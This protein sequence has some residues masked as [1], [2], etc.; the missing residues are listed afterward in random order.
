MRERNTWNGI[1][2]IAI[3]SIFVVACSRGGEP[4]ASGSASSAPAAGPSETTS[5]AAAHREALA[6]K[7]FEPVAMRPTAR[8]RAALDALVQP[9]F[10]LPEDQIRTVRLIATRGLRADDRIQIIRRGMFADTSKATQIVTKMCGEAPAAL[11]DQVSNAKPEVQSALLSQKCKLES[12]VPP[13]VLRTVDPSLLLAG[14]VIAE[15]ETTLRGT[16]DAHTLPDELQLP[17]LVPYV[18]DAEIERNEAAKMK[19]TGSASK[20]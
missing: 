2:A 8:A 4:R 12:F 6:K 13:W 20:P 17:G 10:G 16:D 14:A 18:V 3:P 5:S 11:L 1:G 19:A 7:V 9:A 15:E